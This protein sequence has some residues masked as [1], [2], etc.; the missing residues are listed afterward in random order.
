MM[1]YLKK[2]DW[3]LTGSVFFLVAVGL[4]SIASISFGKGDFFNLE[5]QIVFI[6]IGFF[7]FFLLGFFDW[8][9][10]RDNPYFVLI[11]YAVC[12]LFLLGLFFF[13]SEIRGVKSWY[14]IGPFSFD[15]IGITTIVL[16]IILAKFFS[17]RH[18]EMYK[19][20]HIILSGFYVFIP[21]VLIA[22]QPDLGSALIL[23]MIW[24]GSLI[25]SAIK[26]KHFIVLLLIGMV[27]FAASWFL[28]L[29]DYQKNRIV[30]FLQPKKEVLGINWSQTQSKIAVGSGGLLGQGFASGS[31]TQH[32]F[33]PE[34]YTDFIFAAFSEEFGLVGVIIL[35]SLFSI[36]LWRIMRIAFLAESN[37]PRLFASGLAIF[38]FSQMVINIGMN[39]GILPVIG[40][41]LP[42]VSYGGSNLIAI[43]IGL[44]ILQSIKVNN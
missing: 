14:K 36:L 6:I 3:I 7:I 25:V 29:K 28:F 2:I 30:S 27:V 31:Q 13:A 21:F 39:L 37:F 10:F 12:N 20:R 18:V 9:G 40:L 23:L 15:P 32:G 16:I 4:I 38:I 19:L 33:L 43:F 26:L 41:P 1:N 24:I 17:K 8:R 11:L 42:L 34:P 5:K 44:G 22:K 35:F